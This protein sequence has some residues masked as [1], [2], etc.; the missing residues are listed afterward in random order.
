MQIIGNLCY[1]GYED[2]EVDVLMDEVG[3]F[4]FQPLWPGY[5]GE[6]EDKTSNLLKLFLRILKETIFNK[7]GYLEY[8]IKRLKES[9]NW[10][11]AITGDFNEECSPVYFM[12]R[13]IDENENAVSEFFTPEEAFKATKDKLS[14]VM[15]LCNG[16]EFNRYFETHKIM[17]LKPRHQED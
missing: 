13:N 11:C 4:Y 7:D 2:L 6:I 15:T 1:D 14:E 10:F 16:D 12:L 3:N 17:V 8:S 9:N 5:Y